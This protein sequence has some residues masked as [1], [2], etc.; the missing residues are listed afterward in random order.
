MEY[1][2]VTLAFT[3][4]PLKQLRLTAKVRAHGAVIQDHGRFLLQNPP[5]L[6]ISLPSTPPCPQKGFLWAAAHSW[7]ASENDEVMNAAV[8]G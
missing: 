6:R 4:P 7:N 3:A 5:P 2:D 1:L 8:L